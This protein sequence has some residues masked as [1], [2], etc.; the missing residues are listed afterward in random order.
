MVFPTIKNLERI[1]QFDTADALL[2][3]ASAHE[4]GPSS[5]ASRGGRGRSLVIDDD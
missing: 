3:W 2:A 5:R 1:A 4:V